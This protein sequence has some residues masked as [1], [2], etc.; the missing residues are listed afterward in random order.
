MSSTLYHVSQ[1]RCVVTEKMKDGN[2]RILDRTP[3]KAP[4]SPQVSQP[5]DPD[6]FSF[7]LPFFSPP[8]KTGN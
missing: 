1:V 6:C 8:G 7:S 5:K 2:K 3:N 4:K